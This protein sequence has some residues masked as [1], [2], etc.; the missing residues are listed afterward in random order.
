MQTQQVKE[1]KTKK[2]EKRRKKEEKAVKIQRKQARRVIDDSDDEDDRDDSGEEDEEVSSLSSSDD[3]YSDSTPSS[4]PTI[5]Q[6]TKI[7]HL[8]SILHSD[9]HTHK[10]IVFS[11]FTSMLDLIEP[12]LR[13]HRIRFTRYDGKMRNDQREA[14]LNSLRTDPATRVLLCSLRA[15]SLGLNLTAAS[16]VVILEPFWNPFVE[17]QAIDRVHRLNQTEDV[18]VYKLTVKGTVE[19]RIL[20]LQERKRE[21]AKSAIEGASGGKMKLTLQ[22]MLRLFGRDAEGDHPIDVNSIDS[23]RSK[24]LLDAGRSI[25]PSTSASQS[26]ST[27]T[28]TG[29]GSGSRTGTF[30]NAGPARA[31][32]GGRD[33][34]RMRISDGAKE[35]RKE[36]EIYGRRW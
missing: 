32:N 18:K 30:Y 3:E 11:F 36:H 12:F 22:D 29:N 19:E 7:R 17:E 13:T 26:T 35:K 1:V 20:D 31:N 8:L 34:E 4:E 5:L 28:G 27:G 16:R 6:S 9:S 14:S 15:G 25:G 33:R 23:R 24:G 10:Y 21:L 2:K